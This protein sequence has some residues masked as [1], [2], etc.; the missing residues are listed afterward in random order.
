MYFCYSGN[1]SSQRAHDLQGAEQE[2]LW[3]SAGICIPDKRWV[4]LIIQGWT[5][6]KK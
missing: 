6:R 5:N 3:W 4:F 1:T 2:Q